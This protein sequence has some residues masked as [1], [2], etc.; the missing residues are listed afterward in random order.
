MLFCR[1]GMHNP[2]CPV[3]CFAAETTPGQAFRWD[4]Y[5][6]GSRP[7]ILGC[8][9][10]PNR[11]Q[12]TVKS[13]SQVPA[14]NLGDV[15]TLYFECIWGVLTMNHTSIDECISN[16]GLM[17]IGCITDVLEMYW[18]GNCHVL[19]MHW[20]LNTSQYIIDVLMYVVRVR[21]IMMYSQ[22][23]CNVLDEVFWFLNNVLIHLNTS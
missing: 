1:Q 23:Y 6:P 20:L 4:P 13:P 22:M 14:K 8:S 15:F 11:A 16:W 21:C 2:A 7:N 12:T 17:Q 18:A 10:G 19:I 9:G 5:S 3:G